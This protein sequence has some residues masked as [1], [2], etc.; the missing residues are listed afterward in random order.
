MPVLGLIPDQD[1]VTWPKSG[2]VGIIDLEFTAWEGSWKRSWSEPWEWREIVQIGFIAVDAAL[3]F[4]QKFTKEI[5]VNPRINTNLSDY[6]QDLTGITQANL[7]LNGVCLKDGLS[8]LND[9]I[10]EVDQIIFNGQDGLIIRENCE[11]QGIDYPWGNH[12]FFNFRPLLAST[13]NLPQSVLVSSDLTSIARI[14]YYRGRAHT[15]LDDCKAIAC[16]LGEW[17][18]KDIL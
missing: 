18:K 11:L 9:S 8:L 14:N 16:A 13:L 12:N 4:E 2:M 3:N 7:N 17:R 5:L 6:F 15:A 10:A 1:L